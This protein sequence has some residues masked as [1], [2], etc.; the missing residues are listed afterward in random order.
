MARDFTLVM[1]RKLLQSAIDGGYRLTTVE[2]YF[3]QKDRHEKVFILRHDVDKL[4]LNSLKTAALQHELGVPGTYYF[5]IVKESFHP[6]VI[7]KI[8]ALGHEIG[9][10]YE[11]V[12]LQ[13]GNLEKAFEKFC[14]HLELIR[15]YYPVKTVCMHGSPLSKWDNRLLWTKYSYRDLGIIAE[16]YFDVDFSKVLYITDTGR[17]WN[18]TDVSIRDKVNSP[19]QFDLTSTSDIIQRFKEGTLPGSIMQNIHPQRWSD[20]LFPWT[21]ELLIQN[22]KNVVKSFVVKQSKPSF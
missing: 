18:K 10:H 22:L 7:E 19:F 16:P 8:A 21:K 9:Y 12:A 13:H 6:D 3:S 11:D 2:N 5:R 17:S 4:P 20:E 1:Y 14:E 15:K